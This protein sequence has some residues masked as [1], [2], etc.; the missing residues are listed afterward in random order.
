MRG[1]NEKKGRKLEESLEFF[2]NFVQ[3]R[4]A[5]LEKKFEGTVCI[6]PEFCPRGSSSTGGKN[7][8]A[9]SKVENL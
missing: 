5:G 8:T 6:L 9:G 4:Q 2:K 3:A 7:G 1:T